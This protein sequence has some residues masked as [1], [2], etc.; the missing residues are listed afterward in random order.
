MALALLLTGCAKPVTASAPCAPPP[1]AVTLPAKPGDVLVNGMI[2]C[3]YASGALKG[4]VLLPGVTLDEFASS[5]L[6]GVG[7]TDEGQ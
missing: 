1:P 2:E 6:W 4:C 5:T 3:G 7:I